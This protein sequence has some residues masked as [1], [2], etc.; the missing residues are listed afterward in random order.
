MDTKTVS[1]KLVDA[2]GMQCA[3]KPGCKIAF[4]MDESVTFSGKNGEKILFSKDGNVDEKLYLPGQRSDINSTQPM[5]ALL[6][7]AFGCKGAKV[8]LGVSSETTYVL[9]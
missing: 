2:D 9:I 7:C 6:A 3:M 4:R 5:A 1:T 8:V